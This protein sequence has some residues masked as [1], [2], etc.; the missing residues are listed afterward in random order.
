MVTRGRI[1][2]SAPRTAPTTVCRAGRSRPRRHAT[3]TIAASTS[4]GNGRTRQERPSRTPAVQLR[5]RCHAHRPSSRRLT[6]SRSVDTRASRASTGLAARWAACQGRPGARLT[7]AS[8]ARPTSTTDTSAQ[9]VKTHCWAARPSPARGETWASSHITAP[10]SGAVPVAAPS[11]AQGSERS[12]SGELTC[13][14][15]RS[16]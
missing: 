8:T 5:S 9:R 3:M 12:A 10:G 16:E 2:S 6:P 1:T 15:G 11:P 7:S 13:T 4:T 14:T